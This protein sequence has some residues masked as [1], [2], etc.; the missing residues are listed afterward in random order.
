MT[1]RTRRPNYGLVVTLT[2]LIGFFIYLNQVVVPATPPFFI[3]TPTPTRSPESFVNQAQQYYQEGKLKQAIEA[4]KQAIL[5]DP[6]N[7]SNYIILARLQAFTGEYDEAVINAQNALLKN[8]N[9]PLAHAVLGWA[10]GFQRKFG[11]AELEIQKA[12]AL[13]PNSALVHAYYA[14]ILVNQGSNI[15]KAADE[16]KRALDLDPTLLEVRRARGLVLLNTQNLN[17]AVDE[18]RAAITINKNIADLHLYLGV[19]Y[20]AL[21]EYDLAQESLLASYALNPNDTIALT[22]LSRAFFAD[23]RFAQAAQ[24][25]EEAIA[26]N[27]QDARLHG[28]L[29]IIYYRMGQYNKAIIEL[30]L[31][32]RGGLTEDGAAVEG[33]PLDYG[34]VM[35][36][37]WFYGFALARSNRCSEAVPVFQALL[38][39]V[40]NDEIA[41]YNATEGLAVCS[42]AQPTP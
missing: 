1:R 17:Q 8:P 32:V 5:A 36:Y 12:L 37:Y 22:E 34:R 23:G 7:P 18:F 21:G 39:G 6:S 16:S 19:T 33:I 10:L 2:V 35:E 15:Q 28:N 31:A 38:T 4:Y 20:K 9:N 14:E 25:A 13:D 27:P 3:P 42:G 24:Y 29:G 11:E 41:V 40:P 26:V 30:G